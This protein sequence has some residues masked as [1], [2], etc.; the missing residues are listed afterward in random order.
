[1]S[2]RTLAGFLVAMLGL[3]ASESTRAAGPQ[4]TELRPEVEAAATTDGSAKAAASI[5]GWYKQPTSAQKG[6][7]L[8][9]TEFSAATQDGAAVLL[10]GSR[11][12]TE[13]SFGGT[14][15]K[16]GGSVGWQYEGDIRN[17]G[18]LLG[19]DKAARTLGALVCEAEC[20]ATPKAA[21][22]DRFRA[23]MAAEERAH[24]IEQAMAVTC[25]E[26]YE[27]AGFLAWSDKAKEL[28]NASEPVCKKAV[29]S[30]SEKLK[31]G[32]RA[33]ASG[34][35]VEEE[36]LGLLAAAFVDAA[37]SCADSCGKGTPLDI[38]KCT[39]AELVCSNVPEPDALE[40]AGERRRCE[41]ARTQC[42]ATKAVGTEEA[43]CAEID[44]ALGKLKAPYVTQQAQPPG[45]DSLCDAGQAAYDQDRLQRKHGQRLARLERYRFPSFVITGGAHFI[46]SRLKFLEENGTVSVDGVDRP[47]LS[48]E[49]ET[50][51]G[52]AAGFAL[53]GL[54][55]D[56]G[57]TIEF[58][59][60][61]QLAHQPSSTKAKWCSAVGGL[62]NGMGAVLVQSCDERALGAPVRTNA[63]LLEPQFGWADLDRGIWRVSVGPRYTADTVADRHSLSLRLPISIAFLNAPRR[64]EKID[65]DGVFR[66]TPY[67]GQTL[68]SA[69][70]ETPLFFGLGFEVLTKRGIFSSRYDT[71]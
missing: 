1:M 19:E 71:F 27:D 64:N 61:Y 48:S 9:N 38:P 46:G 17:V 44:K 39:Y 15:W 10:S 11:D 14:D 53:A 32:S 28:L 52:A 49:T 29:K 54:I 62:D 66:F 31:P 7:F 50:R 24:R 57:A 69:D 51:P 45:R 55:R 25:L 63:F 41:S 37:K 47:A 67:V 59:F 70:G 5:S 6:T 26:L 34:G 4:K 43:V 33:I 8:W 2:Y 58:R 68:A 23:P 3:L 21:G 60:M 20:T 13:R 40:Y 35:R 56:P 36:E 18:G 42:D 22:C 12:G 16:V 30:F 65:F